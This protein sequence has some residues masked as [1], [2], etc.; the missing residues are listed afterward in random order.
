MDEKHFSLVLWQFTE[1]FGRRGVG[2]MGAFTGYREKSQ[3]YKFH[4][5]SLF[6]KVSEIYLM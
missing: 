2:K 6:T 4:L 1:I 3:S 5:R